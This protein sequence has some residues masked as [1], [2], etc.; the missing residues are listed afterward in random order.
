MFEIDKSPVLYVDSQTFSFPLVSSSTGDA[1]GSSLN[2]LYNPLPPVPKAKR[3]HCNSM[4]WGID[5]KG[6]KR[7]KPRGLHKR[8]D[9]L[10]IG[11][12]APLDPAATRN[13]RLNPA[14]PTVDLRRAMQGA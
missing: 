13:G 4:V 3:C 6:K 7:K 2:D 11:K 9:R 1:T 8:G 5:V 14:Q 12:R 10:P